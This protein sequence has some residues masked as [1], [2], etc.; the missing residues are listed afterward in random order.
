MTFFGIIGY[1]ILAQYL[2]FNYGGL[3]PEQIRVEKEIDLSYFLRPNY[4]QTIVTADSFGRLFITQR[5]VKEDFIILEPDGTLSGSGP[6]EK[7]GRIYSFDITSKGDPVILFQ[8]DAYQTFMGRSAWTLCFYDGQTL[9]KKAEWDDA[10]LKSRFRSIAQVKVLRP[11]DL[12][13]VRG[14]RN[15]SIDQLKS[16]HIV[17]FE[18]NILRSFSDY[19]KKLNPLKNEREFSD[20]FSPEMLLIDE[21]NRRIFQKF[22]F[23][24]KVKVFDYEGH[25]LDEFPWPTSEFT[26]FAVAGNFLIWEYFPLSISG[27]GKSSHQRGPYKLVF[28]NGHRFMPSE[29]EIPY[30]PAIDGVLIGSNS[31]GQ[32]YFLS[33]SSRQIL[34]IAK[35]E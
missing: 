13:L 33:G 34:K 17:D 22:Y 26:N 28:W 8:R 14:I 16:L 19:E 1:F 25:L 3:F 15:G 6:R 32:L 20:I 31:Q 35:I 30:N 27:E 7:E 21:V 11:E 2:L 24:Q 9:N 29:Q 10:F 5:W 23:S 12:L 4:Y 18:G